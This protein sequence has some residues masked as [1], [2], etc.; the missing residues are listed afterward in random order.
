[1]FVRAILSLLAA[2]GIAAVVYLVMTLTGQY[3]D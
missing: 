2:G 1:M 3:R